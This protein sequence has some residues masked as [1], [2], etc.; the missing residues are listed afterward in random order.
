MIDIA[1]F[2][3]CII[4]Y[5][6]IHNFIISN[7][8]NDITNLRKFHNNIKANLI[9]DY[10]KKANAKKLLDIACG[11]GGDLSKWLN[12]NLNLTYIFAFDNH[13]Q[14]IY[15]SIKKGGDFDGAIARF[16]NIKND[17]IKNKHYKKLPFIQFSYLNMLSPNIL[18][19][20]NK[21]DS[22]K[23]YDIVSCQFAL[24]YFSQNDIILNNVLNL[25]SQKLNKGGYFIGT[26]TDGDLINNILNYGNVN[27][28]LLQLIKKNINEYL[29]YI[30]VNSQ[31]NITQNYFE[32]QGISNEFFLFKEKLK[33][34]AIKNNL[35]LIEYKSFYEY[36]KQYRNE[37]NKILHLSI[38]EMIISFLNFSFVFQKI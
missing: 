7:N 6:K 17:I 14:S 10:C 28:P 31:E 38:Y 34:I 26:A 33:T 20:L 37:K 4:N 16:L 21:Q 23:I 2:V 12:K 36:Y 13:K 5:G 9:I 29:F 18:F 32:L 15:S 11:R 3:N 30:N 24:H 1:N 27:I 35:I 22:N 8:V 25:V 19:E